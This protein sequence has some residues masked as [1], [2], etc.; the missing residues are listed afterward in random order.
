MASAFNLTAQ[1]NLRGPD[2]L[3]PIVAQIRR[4]LGGITAD[5][6]VKLDQRGAKSIDLVS[7]RLNAMNKILMNTKNNVV[8]LNQSLRDLSGSLSA[9]QSGSNVSASGIAKV[10][11]NVS[12]V[13]K[14]IQ[15]ARTE[16]EEF[17]K[18]SALA[19][20][21]FAAFS[22]VT[23][24]V[25]ALTNAINAGFKAFISFDREL[26]K[27]QQV[28]GKGKL[29][30]KD[31]EN[32]ITRL[33]TSLGVSSESLMTVASTLAQAGLSANETKIALSALAKTELAPSFDN[34]T[35]TTEGAIAAL[36]QFGLQAQDL[37]A[38]LGSINAVAAAFAVESKDIITAIQRTGGVF[39]A[40]SKG[41]SEG[42][43]A[44]NEFIAVFTSVRAT[45]RE[46][47]ETIATG[48]RTIF[49][50]IQRADTIKQL[51]QFGVELQDLE[52][53]FV[54][55]F[56]AVKRLS[57]ALLKLDP[58]DVRF[59][60]IVEELGGFRQIGKVIP[61]IQQFATAQQALGVAQKGTG[62][63]TDAQIKAQQSL[64]NQI[65]KVREQ[66]LALIR[67]IG[68]STVFQGLF[69]IVLGL[70]SGFLSL[71]SA[72]KPILPILAVFTAIK[73][74]SAVGQFASGFF[75]GLKKGG[76]AGATGQNIGES[77]SGAKEKER[78]AATAKAASAILE[79]T[80]ALS[81]LTTAIQSL[82]STIS[83]RG[84]TTLADGGR[85]LG[86]NKGGLVPGNGGGDTVPAYLE[87]GEIVMNRKAVQKY[88]ASNLLK[89]NKYADG[90]KINVTA[91]ELKDR[92]R[93][94]K[95]VKSLITDDANKTTYTSGKAINTL[96]NIS[97]NRRVYK[98]NAP[99]LVNDSYAFEQIVAK[100]TNG[101][102]TNIGK[103]DP[104][105]PI[106]ITNSNYGP[107]E[108]RNRKSSTSNRTLLDKLIRYYISDKQ[109]QRLSNQPS[110]DDI[111]LGNI[112][113]VY[114][115]A[116][117]DPPNAKEL[118]IGGKIQK[119]AIGGKALGARSRF[120]EL[121]QEEILKLS[122]SDLLAYGK[123]LAEDI[124]TTGGAGIA[125]GN[126]FIE[127]PPE[128]IIPELEPY[129]MDHMGQKG[130]W[131]EKISPFG[132]PS[133]KAIKQSSIM[134]RKTALE[135]Q[136]AKQADEVAAR[137][138]QW[139]QIREGSDIDKYLLSTLV[140]PILSDYKSV[141]KGESL[142]K[143]F[144]NTRLRQS[145]NK[146]LEEY[147]DFDY[148]ASNIDKLV[149]GFATKNFSYG[150]LVQK[151]VGG[152][153]GGVQGSSLDPMVQ[154][155]LSK[156]QEAGGSRRVRELLTLDK[157]QK[158]ISKVQTTGIRPKA[159]NVFDKA[160]LKSPD[161]APFLS[162]LSSLAD[163]AI[164][165][166]SDTSETDFKLTPEQ[167]ASARDVAIAGFQ[168]DMKD[169]RSYYRLRKGIPL[170][171]HTGVISSD[172]Y[173]II[174]KLL[175]KQHM[176]Q[177]EAAQ[178]FA[179]NAKITPLKKEDRQKFGEANLGGYN[180][181][182]ILALLGSGNGKK[183]TQ[184]AIDF[185]SGLTPLAAG[186]FGVPPNIPTQAKLTVSSSNV[187]KALD[188]IIK[189]FA[190]GGK[191]EGPGFEEV[192]KQIMDKYPAIDFRISKRKKGRGFGYNLL[193]ALKTD[194]GLLQSKGLKFE[195]PSNLQQLIE[196]SD[197]M[198]NALLNPRTLAL[199]GL[200]EATGEMQG[201]M[202]GLYGNRQSQARP[203]A[204]PQKNFGKI[205][206][207]SSAS[208]IT[209]TY[210]KNAE[211]EGFVSAKKASGNLYTIGLSKA[212]KGYGPR[213][214]D[215]VMEAATAAGGM[216]TSDRNQV[217]DAARAVWAYY[218]NNRSDVK[219]TPLDPSQWTKNQSYIDP[220]LY[221]KKETWPPPNDP[222]WI[223]QS[224][225][226]KSPELINSADIIN[227]N[228]PKY[229]AF[230]QQQQLGFMSRHSGGLISNF[231]DGGVLAKVSNGEA[232]VP[233]KLAKKIGY[234]KLDKMN[235]ADR[236]GMKGYSG[237]G[238]ISLF[239]GPGN[240]TSDSI[241]PVSLPVGSY[242]IRE[243]ATKALGLHK[244]GG[245]ISRK[246]A[247]G[248]RLSKAERK[249]RKESFLAEQR[250]G[251]SR[252]EAFTAG[253]TRE[254]FG[255]SQI[256]VLAD[257]K[258]SA[259][260][261]ITKAAETGVT[262]PVN[263][264]EETTVAGPGGTIVKQKGRTVTADEAKALTEK[265]AGGSTEISTTSRKKDVTATS[266]PKQLD[267]IYKKIEQQVANNYKKL[268]TE[269]KKKI[270]DLYDQREADLDAQVL[271]GA[272]PVSDRFDQ[273]LKLDE[274]RQKA[275]QE[276]KN[277]L[278]TEAQTA[279][280][281]AVEEFKVG[282]Q[283][284]TVNQ[285]KTEQAKAGDAELKA[286]TD[287]IAKDVTTKYQKLYDEERASLRDFYNQRLKQV[288]AEGG[289]VSEVL[290]EYRTAVADAKKGM[291]T[292]LTAEI[293]TQQE[294]APEKLKQ[295]KMAQVEASRETKAREADPFYDLNKAMSGVDGGGG[296]FG[297]GPML[298][299]K[300]QKEQQEYFA[301][302]AEK[303]GMSV[304]GYKYSLSQQVG[305]QK[306][307]IEQDRQF[308]KQETK[309]IAIGKQRQLRGLGAGNA[310]DFKQL[311]GAG[312][313]SKE[314]QTAQAAITEFTVNLQKIAP[315]MDPAEIKAAATELAT[316]LATTNQSVEE[317]I[318]NAPDGSKL[319]EIFQKTV[320]DAEVLNEAIKRVADEAG[321]SAET[322]KANVSSK[323]IQQQA[324]IQSKEGQRFGA[325]AQFAPGLTEKFSKT[326]AG[327]AL[328]A[329]AD[330]ISGKGGKLSKAFAGAGGF[331]GIGAG[332]AVGAES[333]KQFLPKSMTSDPNTAGALGALGGAGSGAAMGAQLGS[334]AGPIGTLIGGIGGALIGGIQGW[335]S[336]KNQ[337]VL[338][339]ALEN[340]AKTT[341]DLDEAFKKLEADSSKVN[342]DNAQKAFGDVV[343][344][345]K[346]IESLAFS[347]TGF[348]NL[349]STFMGGLDK[350]SQGFAEGD[351]S[352][353][354]LGGLQTAFGGSGLGFITDYFSA[355][356]EAQRTEAIGAMVGGAGQKQ[357]AAV[358]LA[359]TQL[360]S[361]STEELGAIFDSIKNGTATLNPITDQYVQGALKA[362]EAA[363][364]VKQ[365]TAAEEENITAQAKERAALDAYM[366]KRKE[367]GATDEQIAKELSKNQ[368][369]AI[370]EGE[371]ALKVQA[372]LVAKQALLARAS[373][374][375]AIAS[376]NLI[377]VYRRISAQAQKY[378]DELDNFSQDVDSMLAGLGGDTNM[379][380]V[381][382]QNE[383][384]LGNVSAYSM[385]EVKAASSAAA[386]MMGGTPEAQKLANNAVGQKIVLDQIPN[387]LRNAKTD[388]ERG[389][390]LEQIRGL[391]KEQGIEGSAIETVLTDLN[392][393]MEKN[394]ETG[395]SEADLQE[396]V[397]KSFEVIGK[398]AETLQA[399]VKKYNDT[400]QQARKFQQDYNK[401]I[402][403]AGSYLRKAT[404][405]RLNAELELAKALGRSPTLEEL[406]KPFDVEIGSLTSKLVGTGDLAAGQASD[407]MAIANAITS[408]EKRK[409]EIEKTNPDLF[410]A[411]AGIPAGAAG[412]PMRE[413]LNQ[414]QLANIQAVGELTVASNEGR[415]A[416]EKL[417]NDGSKAA[418]AL[419]K[420]QEEQQAMEG[421]G[422]FAQ[423]VFTAEPEELAKME[424]NAAALNASQNAGP[425]FFKS[426][427]NRQMAFAG[428]E[429]KR[430]FMLPEEYRKERAQLIRKNF[431]AQGK[432][433]DDVV[434]T[435]GGKD[436]TLD[437]L[438]KRLEGGVDETDPNVIEF[439]KATEI[440]AQANEALGM[441]NV[442]Q[443]LIVE[444]A[445]LRLEAF[446]TDKFPNIIAKGNADAQEANKPPKMPEAKEKK[447]SATEEELK[448]AKTERD[449]RVAEEKKAKE[450]AKNTGGIRWGRGTGIDEMRAK[451]K[452]KEAT[453]ARKAADAK[454]ADL[455]AKAKAEQ[456]AAAQEQK[457]QDEQKTAADE[458]AKVKQKEADKAESQETLDR[459]RKTRTGENRPRPTMTDGST[460]RIPQSQVE[461]RYG[462]VRSQ[463]Q[464]QQSTTPPVQAA[465]P[466]DK[467]AQ[468]FYG[469]LAK[470]SQSK[471]D[472]LNTLKAQQ[473]K[474]LAQKE[475]RL[476]LV[477]SAAMAA[478]PGR[479]ET[480]PYVQKAQEEFD[481]AQRGME[482]INQN[483][484][485][486]Q[487]RLS[488]FRNKA[489]GK[490]TSIQSS[491]TNTS[492]NPQTVPNTDRNET[493]RTENKEL[494]Q[495]TNDNIEATQALQ[496]PL[497]LV[498]AMATAALESGS[499]YTHDV[500][501]EE[502]LAI[503]NETMTAFAAMSAGDPGFMVTDTKVLEALNTMQ[504][505]LAILEQMA[506]ASIAEG[507]V[508]RDVTLA[509]VAATITPA[510]N[511]VSAGISGLLTPINSITGVLAPILDT[512]AGP[513][514][515]IASYFGVKLSDNQTRGIVGGAMVGGIP[516]AI[517]G[518]GAGTT[519]DA[520]S[521]PVSST[522][523]TSP[524]I[525]NRAELAMN[526]ANGRIVSAPIPATKP[527]ET[528]T[529]SS[530]N[531][532]T[533]EGNLLS[534]NTES[535]EK[536]AK[537]NIDFA[538]YVDKLVNFEFPSI[539]EKIEMSGNHVVDVRITGA[540][541]FEGLK[542]D[543]TNMMQTEI[544]KAMG[545][546]WSQ[547]GGQ[548]GERPAGQGE[549]K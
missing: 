345:G 449:A 242:V 451:D 413:Q 66:F 464:A 401:A 299:A 133:Q 333:L 147:D 38:V 170:H 416:L 201:L 117:Y 323:T 322:L 387:L 200:A 149:S 358:K 4:E 107:L 412:D 46:S 19:V 161:A 113:L 542:K 166:F 373:K 139:T 397:N 509:E 194:G 368:G 513:I 511:T 351:I 227:M 241:G 522:A 121:S 504:T 212:S 277:R 438:T 155:I 110:F 268:Y 521:K 40:A 429:Q 523:P 69:K 5:V 73:G 238:G 77:L 198:A 211:R 61:L 317:I 547:S 335:F 475:K 478:G 389:A 484:Q 469:R 431:E 130:F 409:A 80:K 479:V 425:E 175:E 320:S 85:V 52:G 70:T 204:K 160:F 181:E 508:T 196:S 167:I 159:S 403:E 100:K 84:G 349:G 281:K 60:T 540:A 327:K 363:N 362:A 379:R 134:D 452:A 463:A 305:Q 366:K 108:V 275:K 225:Y 295:Q 33:A 314:A 391:L 216:L 485:E 141:R 529:I 289:D 193:G 491:P 319:K 386:G 246:L 321:I 24:A 347:K 459:T 243:K 528:T 255:G 158:E 520:A 122:T 505:P 44:L 135:A 424:I 186:V 537:F 102:L 26:V 334:F 433:G 31:L 32:E 150:G 364:G 104:N 98:I 507:I 87:G 462:S 380:A 489:E 8:S 340:V 144:H 515:G 261:R 12:S 17:G 156:L 146:A 164:T 378:S 490:P 154:N 180:L 83:K 49:T 81:S 234:A 514:K 251:L 446:L 220:K 13:A 123:A 174:D 421:F 215:V 276:A 400:L 9:V 527:S 267:A 21:R 1:I 377:D 445:M 96:D 239:K 183:T 420:I 428:L 226:S 512:I 290:A 493:D 546:I 313:E 223:L 454:V 494:T 382:R 163:E 257:V 95:L 29:G 78:T 91:K 535:L 392:N 28:T 338:T 94:S 273:G 116:K 271:S 48:L 482:S 488:D 230:I 25:F 191:A 76:G 316:G 3:K 279:Q 376:E 328:G 419:A 497:D 105:Y 407:P 315:S 45:T 437:E 195:Q 495:L 260:E 224:G 74:V 67:D 541:A 214:Y 256:D 393:T 43:D 516:G 57:E 228:D 354:V 262:L 472:E 404:Q 474:E 90:G 510:I 312:A 361:K 348:E 374:E 68:Q 248:G 423:K 465:Q 296:P 51:K 172:K 209:A 252:E 254:D 237:G 171:V 2:N 148:S 440:Q 307:N 264:S 444:R 79:N 222:A 37:E 99:E 169:L 481:M 287:Q 128:R 152:S 302:K 448:K 103:E 187:T 143:P 470:D 375:V 229:A 250:G 59:S 455:E 65:S 450:D 247:S 109:F 283:T 381:N 177:V 265:K 432:K 435:I 286:A 157:I 531:T 532:P 336:G 140:D 47:A 383:Q 483:I 236:N 127:V 297:P 294:S 208:E 524:Q 138:Q 11:N 137:N 213:L 473:E 548:M 126:E 291:Q 53:K 142:S 385:E 189:T 92:Y 199:G 543:F 476:K 71:A 519:V 480:S 486:E 55:P 259:R 356:S 168:S 352:K 399:V 466:V 406:N 369:A 506:A 27:L 426:R 35:E 106:D 182:A 88:G 190:F 240:G 434:T 353:I 394:K 244:H 370:K 6:N 439:R 457:V 274:E 411:G 304:S 388:E 124:F 132:K 16:M 325:L 301:R 492:R 517:A 278:T 324:F 206:L 326:G 93:G 415:Q 467:F 165:A 311:L 131:R 82:Q 357:E 232:F 384:I 235:Q 293:K 205:G 20:R 30:I 496:P 245:I 120:K 405:V 525:P 538:S 22:V 280:S 153:V 272:L 337:A 344:A 15:V 125:I 258:K 89:M 471:L 468:G 436:I 18:Q 197:K 285:R 162:T 447:P 398:G 500:T 339:N 145:V 136:V 461:E 422:N 179:P 306:Y 62:S 477:R 54:G 487:Q 341:G 503:L 151:L 367:S 36:R 342:F 42:K 270:D 430:E 310:A 372:E 114:N 219:K 266:D 395:S 112:G 396:S 233:P 41:V 343:N 56:E 185:A 350:T 359:E 178:E 456:E 176:A 111:S 498:A 442:E 460:G 443:A 390:A 303:A 269:E 549:N 129:L 39:A 282:K 298:N 253:I 536:L 14:N 210:F 414:A 408:A 539:P 309:D 207:R 188:G 417:A 355:P 308:A 544:K 453:A 192:K 173:P 231:A 502:Q 63:L 292:A 331:S 284:T 427:Q 101:I 533:T 501:L 288:Q 203:E 72:F 184:D 50:R 499:I 7:N 86:F 518:Y 300:A 75:G 530:P 34:L 418:N 115:S 545:K 402:L 23:S 263:M 119:L 58:R 458:A 10:S 64:A 118:N 329:G 218:F 526:N 221:G 318:N 360:Q 534:L 330:F 346:D 202:S 97:F 217:S 371:A 332:L 249:K 365:L 441:L 410:A